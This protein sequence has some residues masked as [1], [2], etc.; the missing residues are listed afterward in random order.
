MNACHRAYNHPNTKPKATHVDAIGWHV[1]TGVR[2][3]ASPSRNLISATL[4]AFEMRF[5][6]AEKPEKER[7][8]L[9]ADRGSVSVLSLAPYLDVFTAHQ[10]YAMSHR[11]A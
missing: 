5:L 3:P 8:A 10:T 7:N 6:Y 11:T 4:C 9:C 1:W 2:I